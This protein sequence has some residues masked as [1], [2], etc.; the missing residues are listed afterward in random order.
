MTSVTFSETQT[1]HS[2]VIVTHGDDMLEKAESFSLALSHSEGE[3]V[4]ILPSQ[5]TVWI[6]DNDEG[7]FN[8]VHYT[9]GG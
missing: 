3:S 4:L 1:S 2:V 8:L 9:T 7:V 6:M 5:S